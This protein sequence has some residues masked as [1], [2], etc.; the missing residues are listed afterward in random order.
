[1]EDKVMELKKK[2]VSFLLDNNILVGEEF[3]R[4][5]AELDF[6]KFCVQIKSKLDKENLMMLDKEIGGLVCLQKTDESNPKPEKYPVK[7]VFSYD[8]EPR[9]R[10]LQDFISYFYSRYDLLRNILIQRRELENPI[11]ITRLKQKRKNDSVAV[12][13]LIYAKVLTKNDNII[14]TVE[15]P[16]GMIKVLI[17]KRNKELHSLARNLVLDEVIGVIGNMGDDIIFSK[18]IFHPDIPYS[19]EFKKAPDNTYAVF[20]GDPHFGSKSFYYKEFTRFIDW[21]CGKVG[22]EEQKEIAKKVGYLFVVGDLV[23]GV[24]IYPGQENDLD[25]SDIYMQYEEFSKYLAKIP[26]H[27]KIIICPGNHDAMRIAEP[28]PP[29]YYDFAESIYNLS[30]VTL[31]SNPSVVNIHAKDGFSGFNV[32]MYH[33]FSFPYYAD[34]I[35]DIRI[36]GGQSRSDLIMKS[37]LQKRHLAP[38]HTSTLY[39]PDPNKDCLVIDK[40]PDFF[41]S[42]HIHRISSS[43][44]RNVTMLNCSSWIRE[45]E[46]Q[47]KMGIIPEPA[48]VP[49]V[50]LQTRDVKIMKFI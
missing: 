39:L 13:G 18:N 24:G 23:E 40:V 8:E 27:I 22:T 2:I 1:M 34:I 28:Q 33:G 37:L 20:L 14:L 9:K 4:K 30:N 43:D 31:V 17:T 11:S 12:V 44:Y 15:D 48:R 45:T 7:V 3:I 16:T 38:T 46:Y 36:A 50:N 6:D 25:I 21:I 29:L 49:I 10:T 5:A 41:I 47:S 32:L 42:G 35:E 19:T 26:K